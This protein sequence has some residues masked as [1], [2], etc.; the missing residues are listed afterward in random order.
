MKQL[1]NFSCIDWCD[2]VHTNDVN[3]FCIGGRTFRPRGVLG[4]G[5]H[6]QGPITHGPMGLVP[7]FWGRASVGAR[8][9]TAAIARQLL[10]QACAYVWLKPLT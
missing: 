9:A 8:A 3:H 2:G 5:Y 1:L 4:N 10:Q 7:M 6:I